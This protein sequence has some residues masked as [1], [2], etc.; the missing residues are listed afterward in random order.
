M[1]LPIGLMNWPSPIRGVDPIHT[2]AV[3]TAQPVYR[4]DLTGEFGAGL[5]RRYPCGDSRDCPA[6]IYDNYDSGLYPNT[7]SPYFLKTNSAGFAAPYTDFDPINNGVRW[8]GIGAWKKVYY[9]AGESIGK[10]YEQSDDSDPLTYRGLSEG[11]AFTNPFAFAVAGRWAFNVGGS[12]VD[13]SPIP[14]IKV[15]EQKAI[16]Y[17]S[18]FFIG[19]SIDYGGNTWP[20]SV[21]SGEPE[22]NRCTH[23]YGVE[24]SRPIDGWPQ[25]PDMIGTM[26]YQFSAMQLYRTGASFAGNGVIAALAGTSIVSVLD[27]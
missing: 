19:G 20:G 4:R 9:R 14:Q 2:P 5:A 11:G 3:A 22:L 23:Y 15:D 7:L 12:D 8:S 16:V 18:F 13:G 26:T 1:I 10:F 17:F 25:T 24:L 27:V 6:S 21:S